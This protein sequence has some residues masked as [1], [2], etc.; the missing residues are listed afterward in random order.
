ML[1]FQTLHEFI[2]NPFGISDNKKNEKYEK[3]YQEMKK[4]KTFK[5]EGYTSIDDNYFIHVIVPSDSNPN[6]CYDVVVLFFTDETVVKKRTTFSNY[7]VKFFSNSPSFIYRYAYL[8]KQNGFLIDFLFDKLDQNF[9]NQAPTKTNANFDLFYDK[10]IFCA[11]RLLIDDEAVALS[12][13]GIILKHK[14]SKDKFFRDIKSFENIKMSSELQNIDKKIN[15]ELE[16][17]KKQIKS[18]KIKNQNRSINKVRAKSNTL[19]NGKQSV[20]RRVNKKS[21]GSKISAKKSTK[22]R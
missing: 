10:S 22:K 20:I 15:K 8:Y 16:E 2:E 7:Y 1:P 17:N 14:K 19:S 18:P 4:K 3:I 21:G 13:L 11:S 9:I 5:I 12:K 6:Q